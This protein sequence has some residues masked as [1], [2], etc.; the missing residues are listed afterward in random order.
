M[1]KYFIFGAG[2]FGRIA[3]DIIGSERVSCF[4]DNDEEKQGKMY[5]GK[6]IISLDCFLNRKENGNIIISVSE[7]K[8][9]DII[10]QLKEKNITNFSTFSEFKYEETK[11]KLLERTNYLE[12]YNRAIEWI[13]NNT[14]SGEGIICNTN[15]TKSYPEVSGYYIPTLLRWGYKELAIQYAQWLCGIQHADGAWYDTEGNAPYIFDTAQVLKGLIA[16]REVMPEVDQHI[17]NGC[18]WILSN[19][20][21]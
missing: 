12:I 19:M 11:K 21:Q 18:N 13:K 4:I 7:D 8:Y 17:I 15:L 14:N 2:N 20:T 3:L 1:E 9:E 16:I 10:A 5:Y 6:E